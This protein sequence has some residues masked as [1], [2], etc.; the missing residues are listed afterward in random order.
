MTDLSQNRFS[1]SFQSSNID[2]HTVIVIA[3]LEVDKPVY[4]CLNKYCKGVCGYWNEVVVYGLMCVCIYFMQFFF[5]FLVFCVYVCF[6]GD[7][8][9]ANNSPVHG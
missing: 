7:D 4:L 1:L 6:R 5:L 3:M 2:Y 8:C 9:W